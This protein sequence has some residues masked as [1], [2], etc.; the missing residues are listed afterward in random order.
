V[1]LDEVNQL[2]ELAGKRVRQ[3][4]VVGSMY[5]V[6]PEKMIKAIDELSSDEV[7]GFVRS[8][9]NSYTRLAPFPPTVTVENVTD[10]PVKLPYLMGGWQLC[11]PGKRALILEARLPEL[12]GKVR[13]IPTKRTDLRRVHDE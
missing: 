6:G 12:A 1:A 5:G 10:E 7:I 3:D 9:Y 4:M 8:Y 2:A 13:V 11:A